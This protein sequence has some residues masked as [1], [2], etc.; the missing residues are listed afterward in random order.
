MRAATSDEPMHST[1]VTMM[2]SSA[3]SWSVRSHCP[4]ASSTWRPTHSAR[5][6]AA[7]SELRRTRTG[8]HDSTQMRRRLSRIHASHSAFS[9]V[10]DCRAPG[11][12]SRATPT[13]PPPATRSRA[14]SQCLRNT[15][16]AAAGSRCP[17][18]G[19]AAPRSQRKSWRTALRRNRRSHAHAAADSDVDKRMARSRRQVGGGDPHRWLPIALAFAH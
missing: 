1:T 4:V 10:H 19:S 9:S 12:G 8:T 14:P 17:A 11:P 7:S 2:A 3:E 18:A 16:S 6:V 13:N 5:S 15:R